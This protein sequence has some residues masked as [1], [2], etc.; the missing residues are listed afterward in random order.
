MSDCTIDWSATDID[1]SNTLKGAD[2]SVGFTVATAGTT[3]ATPM[4]ERVVEDLREGDR[5]ITRDN[6]IQ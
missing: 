5:I 6:G 4:G 3:I 1:G 2:G